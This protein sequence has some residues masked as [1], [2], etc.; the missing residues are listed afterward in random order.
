MPLLGYYYWVV[1]VKIIL[2]YCFCCHSKG[3]VAL[4]HFLTLYGFSE[5]CLSCSLVLHLSS[6]CWYTAPWAEW[7]MKT[8]ISMV[9]EAVNVRSLVLAGPVSGGG[10][11]SFLAYA[12]RFPAM[13]PHSRSEGCVRP[14]PQAPQSCS[15]SLCLQDL[16]T[17]S[18]PTPPSNILP[19]GIQILIYEFRGGG[20][21]HSDHSII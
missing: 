18:I 2:K 1:F 3:S 7:L 8:F 9:C 4:I 14:L 17:S 10:G 12:W 20:G 15:Q 19:L 5:W 6:S 16:F 21:A 13:S 11:D